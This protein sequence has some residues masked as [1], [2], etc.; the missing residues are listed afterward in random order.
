[1]KV[2]AVKNTRDLDERGLIMFRE[3][4]EF[5]QA[6]VQQQRA[7]QVGPQTLLDR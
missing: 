1:M 2:I 6:R 3:R 5:D 7:V 4:G